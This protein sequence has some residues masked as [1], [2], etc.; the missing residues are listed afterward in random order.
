M[1]G[2]IGG[3]WLLN[4]YPY[5][6]HAQ[7]DGGLDDLDLGVANHDARRSRT[8]RLSNRRFKDGRVWFAV[9]DVERGHHG[10]DY[11]SNAEIGEIL[12][13]LLRASDLHVAYDDAAK[14]KSA[15]TFKE[16]AAP[17]KSDTAGDAGAQSARRTATRSASVHSAP[18]R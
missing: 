16:S 14:P 6:A 18:R 15:Q 2:A 9:A 5:R 1:C 13:V 3:R 12:P 7:R 4:G 17:A 11:V 10:I 8:S